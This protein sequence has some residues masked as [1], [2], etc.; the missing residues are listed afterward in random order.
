MEEK[1]KFYGPP[2]VFP[3]KS[4]IAGIVAAAL[5][6]ICNFTTTT[7]VNGR[8][9]SYTDYAAIGL[10]IVAI[11]IG[12][13]TIRLWEKTPDSDLMKRRGLFVLILG[14]GAFQLARG[15]GLLI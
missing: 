4:E 12:L 11:L 7:T 14:L 9:T 2:A 15:L 5:P 1:E 8:V 3:D 6:F 10:G 13:S